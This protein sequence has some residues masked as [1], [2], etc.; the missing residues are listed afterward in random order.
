FSSFN[1]MDFGTYIGGTDIDVVNDFQL[2][3]NGDVVFAGTT[4]QISEINGNVA[5]NAT[6]RDVLFGRIDVPASGPVSFSI[7]EKIGGSGT[8]DG[9]GILNIGD[10]VSIIVGQTNSNNFPMGT[11]TPFQGTASGNYDGFVARIYNDGTGGC[12]ASYVGGSDIDILVSV[13]PVVLDH[14]VLLLCFGTTASTDLAVTNFNSGTLYSSTNSSP[15]AGAGSGNTDRYD[16]MFLICNL[17]FSTKYYLSYIGGDNNDYLGATGVPFGSNHLFYNATDSVLYLGTTTHS[18]QSTQQPKFVGRGIVDFANAG[19]PVFDSTKNNSD[20]DTHLI[21]AISTTAIYK[22]LDV[23]WLKYWGA[24]KPDCSVQLQWETTNESQI[25]N[26][27][28]ERSFDGKNFEVIGSVDVGYQQYS[29]NDV[30]ASS[31]SGNQYYRIRAIDKKGHSDI[32]KTI[33]IR[34]CDSQK[35]GIKAYPT[36]AK[37][38]ITIEGLN[39]INSKNAII[40]MYNSSGTLV[41]EKRMILN[42]GPIS[43]LL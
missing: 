23:Q 29:F 22:I 7:L 10:S 42:N 9:Y 11:G 31:Y 37:D 32:S 12:Q 4:A 5:N 8:D 35:S 27:S 20:N 1:T 39:F 21:L 41:T 30:S 43:F 6:G 25:E 2:L 28:I 18:N 36:I 14:Q 13:R 26:Y 33:A 3:S 15:N 40:Q 38:Q 17:N 19:V 16:M 24:L 34:L